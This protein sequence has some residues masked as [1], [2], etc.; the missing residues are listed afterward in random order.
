[1]DYMDPDRIEKINRQKIERDRVFILKEEM[2]KSKSGFTYLL[3]LLGSWMVNAGE[4]LRKRYSF[5]KHARKLD[6]LQ[7]TSRI[8]KA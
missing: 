6:F 4:K 8:F 3:N 2:L 5:A 7:D 1:M